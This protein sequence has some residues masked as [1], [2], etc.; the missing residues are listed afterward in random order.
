V[1][2]DHLG[3]LAE[4]RLD[5]AHQRESGVVLAGADEGMQSQHRGAAG[6][7]EEFLL[8]ERGD[9]RR[10]EGGGF[11]RLFLLKQAHRLQQQG[12]GAAGGACGQ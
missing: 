8:S 10:E 1:E 9:L 3:D 11:G 5:L 2:G 6:G 12:F 7:F 4:V